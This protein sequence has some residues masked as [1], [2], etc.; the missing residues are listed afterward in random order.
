MTAQPLGPRVSRL[1]GAFEQLDQR[2]GDLRSNLDARFA[3]V[4]VRFIQVE[5]RLDGL[6]RKIDGLRSDVDQKFLW[7]MG[8]MFGSWVT[9]I[10]AIFFHR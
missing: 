8:I 5:N 3:Q 10:L 4:D 6:D 9:I 7:M 2:L 1:E